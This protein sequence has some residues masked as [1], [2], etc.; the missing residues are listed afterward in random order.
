MPRVADEQRLAVIV[1]NDFAAVAGGSDKVAIAEAAGLARRGHRVTLV[2]G[3]G[4]PDPELLEAGVSVRLTGQQS[5]LSDPNR[6]RAAAQGIWNPAA[7]SLV[8]QLAAEQGAATVVHVH[9]FTKV[10]SPSAVRAAVRSGLPTVATLHD[11]FAACPNGGFFNYRT[12]QICQLRPLSARCVATNCDVRAYSQKLWRV[13]RAAVQRRFGEVPAGIHDCIV[14]SHF[15]AEVLRPWLAPEAC[16][17]VLANPI[18]GVPERPADVAAAESFVFAGRLRQ[19]KG[20]VDFALAARKAGVQA[21][22]VGDGEEA[23]AIRDADPSAELTG[24]L[25]PAGVHS[26]IRAARAVV[27]PSLWYE[28][29]PLLPLEA[30]AHGVPVIVA[31][32]GAAREAVADGETGLW[33][34][35]GDAEDLAAKLEMLA[36]DPQLAAR[37][38]AAAYERFWAGRWDIATHVD[39]LETIYRAAVDRAAAR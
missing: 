15:A 27:C 9:G 12:N 30:A 21:V 31:D 13:G 39:R 4:E 5:T 1:V 11:Y 22:F 37:L 8:R 19:E 36:G 6:P 20:P 29:Q 18:A 33:F 28:V 14:P 17:H 7:A 25:D 34:R 35:A 2:A 3:N 16:V 24:W 23:D 38:G 10:L 32:A 26:A